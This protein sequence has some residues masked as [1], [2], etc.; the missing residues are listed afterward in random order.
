[1]FKN[2]NQEFSI[3]NNFL[4]LICILCHYASGNGKKGKVLIKNK[5]GWLGKKRIK[6]AP[7]I[8]LSKIYAIILQLN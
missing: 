8:K 5:G 4:P 1:M 7:N 2:Q 3:K 6:L